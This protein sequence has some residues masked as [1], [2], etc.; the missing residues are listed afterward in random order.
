MATVGQPRVSTIRWRR[1][2]MV[3]AG[4]GLA[5]LVAANAHFLYVAIVSQPE[6]VPHMKA[7][8][9]DGRYRAAR[10]AC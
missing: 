1:V 6:C 5:L 10:S 7:P 8:G 3:V 4:I 2:A 9:D